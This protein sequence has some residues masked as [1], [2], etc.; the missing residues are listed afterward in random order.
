MTWSNNRALAPQAIFFD[1]SSLFLGFLHRFQ[2]FVVSFLSVF[3]EDFS[4]FMKNDA[5]FEA[6]G[7]WLAPNLEAMLATGA[8]A[9]GDTANRTTAYATRKGPK[10]LKR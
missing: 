3:H 6:L 8:S 10:L 1:F 5:S 4:L 7:A 2:L 9:E